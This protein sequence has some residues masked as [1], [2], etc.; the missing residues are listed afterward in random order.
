MPLAEYAKIA[1]MRQGWDRAM[2]ESIGCESKYKVFVDCSDC[3]HKDDPEGCA[4]YR[5]DTVPEF[6]AKIGFEIRG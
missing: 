5:R 2:K 1:R 4:Q 6:N 3:R